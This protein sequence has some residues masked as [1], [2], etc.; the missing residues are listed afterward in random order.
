M[1]I[2]CAQREI[3]ADKNNTFGIIRG[4]FSLNGFYD[5]ARFKKV[6]LEF[7]SLFHFCPML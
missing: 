2:I 7:A 1:M 6:E 5:I 3:R 4:S